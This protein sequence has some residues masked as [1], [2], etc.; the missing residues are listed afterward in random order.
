MSAS[1][2]SVLDSTGTARTLGTFTDAAGA[3]RYQISGDSSLTHYAAGQNQITPVAA[4]KACF[5]IAGNAT[6]TVR[7]K[8]ITLSGIATAAAEAKFAIKKTSDA[9]TLGSATISSMTVAPLD[10]TFAA[11]SSTPGYIQTA[12]YT[13][14]PTSVG[15]IYTGELNLPATGSG[16]SG[17]ALD[18]N[19][20]LNGIPAVVLRGTSQL[21][22]VD[23]LG[24][25]LASGSKYSCAFLWAEDA[26]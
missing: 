21:V 1:S 26:S 13:T 4:I 11:A 5:L 6:T 9:G 25:S 22:I 17:S 14:E 12:V 24:A 15:T 2:L 8:R 10:S 18:I 19:F 20:G 16:V 7:L 23:F 3:Q